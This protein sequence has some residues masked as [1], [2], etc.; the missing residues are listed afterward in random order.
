[1]LG[2][3]FIIGWLVVGWF[4]GRSVVR[5]LGAEDGE[6]IFVAVLVTLMGPLGLLVAA[7][8]GYTPTRDWSWAGRF[9]GVK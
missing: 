9:W 3:L 8:F 1:M 5:E 7:A 6:V 4:A 2:V